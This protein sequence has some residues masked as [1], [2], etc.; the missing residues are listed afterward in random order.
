MKHAL[1]LALSLA[2]ALLAA[3]PTLAQESEGAAAPAGIT[4]LL[5]L[6]GL[7]AVSFIGFVVNTRESEQD[8]Q[9]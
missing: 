6:A 4:M 7:G 8:S 9:E 2:L 1:S 5:L 3:L